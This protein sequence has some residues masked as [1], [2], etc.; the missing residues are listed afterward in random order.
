MKTIIPFIAL[1]F[2][3]CLQLPAQD[4]AAIGATNDQVGFTLFGELGGKGFFSINAG[5]RLNDHHRISVGLTALDYDTQN[6]SS[7]DELDTHTW[8]S[9]GVMYYYLHGSG[10]SRFELGAGISTSPFL[11][12]D[13]K[14]DDSPLSLHAVIGY[15]YQKKK[16]LLFRA[17]LTP[18]YRPRVWFL[19]L[20]GVSF[21][22]NW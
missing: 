2:I 15:R 17:G 22:Y 6:E 18:F 11:G 9:P 16:G 21:G 10:K 1:Y 8:P 19:P 14:P 20:I 12:E 5:F 4:D 7:N 13:Y 3:I